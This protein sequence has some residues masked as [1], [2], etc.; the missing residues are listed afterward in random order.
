M[1]KIKIYKVRSTWYWYVENP[2]G[3]GFGS[4]QVSTRKSVIC[5]AIRGIPAGAKVQLIQA[6]KLLCEFNNTIGFVPV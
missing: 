2:Q 1:Y 6:G 3:G 5:R 4:N